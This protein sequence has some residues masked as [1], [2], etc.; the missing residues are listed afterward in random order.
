MN[1]KKIY[2]SFFILFCLLTFQVNVQAQVLP[3]L[4]KAFNQ[5]QK[6]TFREKIY[7]HTDR[8][9]YLTGELLWFKI[10]NVDANSN[11][12]EGLSKLAYVEVIDL[13]NNP[14]LQAKISLTYGKGSGSFYIPV[15]ITNGHYKLRAYTK[16]MQNQGPEAFFEKQ[17]TFVN[18]LSSPQEQKI[19]SS[20]IDL[21]FFPEGGN[22]IS[23]ID[24]NV[25]KLRVLMVRDR[26]CK[27]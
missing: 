22:L 18:P 26:H 13:N 11:K 1:M 3:Q 14:V 24:N 20:N 19:A 23:E 15:S 8:D 16:W 27:A 10:Y 6:D 21:Q 17:L 4:E 7:V 25:L 9:F 2:T 12:P 5:Y